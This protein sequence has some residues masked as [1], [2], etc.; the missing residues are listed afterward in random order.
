MRYYLDGSVI[1]HLLGDGAEFADLRDWIVAHERETAT[2]VVARWEATEAMSDPA[3]GRRSQIRDFVAALPQV[4]VSGKAVEVGSY[5]VAAVPPYA[6]LHVGIAAVH[7]EITAV[8][9][10]DQDVATASRLYGLDVLS[11]GWDPDWYIG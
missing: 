2:S 4:P 11:P 3:V 9:T 6:A 5:A 1:T 10:Y 7:D 8:V